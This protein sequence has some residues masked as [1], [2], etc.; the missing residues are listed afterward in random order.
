MI[1]VVEVV[2]QTLNILN[3][4]GENETNKFALV[5]SWYLRKIITRNEDRQNL[6]NEQTK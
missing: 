1:I 3:S 6:A 2:I 5:L 4:I